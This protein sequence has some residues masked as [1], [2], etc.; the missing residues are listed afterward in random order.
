MTVILDALCG[1]A[2]TINAPKLLLSTD[3][4]SAV[5]LGSPVLINSTQY[6]WNPTGVDAGSGFNIATA[7]NEVW[8]NQTYCFIQALPAAAVTDSADLL[9]NMTA[10]IQAT[11]ISSDPS[12]K[13]LALHL[14]KRNDSPGYTVNPQIS[15]QYFRQPADYPTN[16][17][18]PS[19]V[20]ELYWS[21]EH[22]IDSKLSALS[23]TS[24]NYFTV[25]EW[26]TG[27]CRVSYPSGAYSSSLG[28][29]R[30]IVLLQKD[31]GGNF[32]ISTA[33]DNDANG[34]GTVPTGQNAKT[35]FYFA[36]FTTSSR[37]I[38]VG[39]TV[40]GKTSG[41]TG[42]V[43][44]SELRTGAWGSS[45]KGVL[46][47]TN[48]GDAFNQS[49]VLQIQVAGVWTDAATLNGCFNGFESRRLS[50]PE[51]KYRYTTYALG[52][53]PLGGKYRFEFYFKRPVGGR[54]DITTGITRVWMTDLQTNV[55]TM[56]AE[57]IGG[58]QH[59]AIED[60]LTR[61]IPFTCYTGLVNSGSSSI[62]ITTKVTDF[63]VYNTYPFAA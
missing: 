43:Q 24:G 55:R 15:F 18:L 7:F 38:S 57:F 61:F 10:T 45:G 39:D 20:D 14:I 49:E 22:L 11:T 29:Y 51:D 28:S 2:N 50:N 25:S 40:K 53:S 13:E 54:T 4:R 30:M 3:F 33:L 5:S 34:W 44:F 48:G 27:G 1:L 41:T 31:S 23:T 35:G 37:Q 32:F 62:D 47:I 9:T 58:I 26:K 42:T 46:V 36:P 17:V 6:R 56:I 21:V 63:R 19:A 60:P 59:G 52:T 12:A 8:G 16:T